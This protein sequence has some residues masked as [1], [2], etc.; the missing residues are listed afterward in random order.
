[1]TRRCCSSRQASTCRVGRARSVLGTAPEQSLKTRPLS[2]SGTTPHLAGNAVGSGD[3]GWRR[4]CRPPV[5]GLTDS[6]VGGSRSGRRCSTGAR[7]SRSCEHGCQR[8][9]RL[10]RRPGCRRASRAGSDR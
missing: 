8:R 10:F 7:P 2:A 4:R 3:L 1:V 6:R 5:D 9:R